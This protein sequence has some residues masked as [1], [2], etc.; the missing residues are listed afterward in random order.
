MAK[1]NIN[2]LP[3]FEGVVIDKDNLDGK[4]KTER[5][6]LTNLFSKAVD[7]SSGTNTHQEIEEKGVTVLNLTEYLDLLAS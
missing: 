3:P 2:L 5:E 6:R 1:E 7:I 4:G